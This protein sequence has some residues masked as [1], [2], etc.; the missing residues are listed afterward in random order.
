MFA[1]KIAENK[2]GTAPDTGTQPAD[3]LAIQRKL[4]VGPA[5]DPLEQEADTMADRVMRMQEPGFVQRK[6]HD[7]EKEEHLQ[8][9]PTGDGQ[10]AVSDQTADTIR[11]SA[12]KGSVLDGSAA[13]FMSSRMGN[14]FGDIKIHTD[15][16]AVQLSREL[17]ARAFT[18]G[19]DIYFNEGEYQPGSESGRHLLAH[20]LT[21]TVQQGGTQPVVQKKDAVPDKLEAKKKGI[22]EALEHSD[23][24]LFLSRLR[25]LDPAEGGSLLADTDF[26]QAIRRKFSGSALWSAFTILFFHGKMSLTQRTL[27]VALSGKKADDVLDA[28]AVITARE[29]IGDPMYWDVLKDVVLVIFE[30]DPKLPD[31]LQLLTL[32]QSEY[33]GPRNLTLKSNEVHYEENAAHHYAID[34]FGSNNRA[35]AYSTTKEFRVV[36]TIRLVDGHPSEH[37]EIKD[38]PYTF[39]GRDESGIP[40]AWIAGIKSIWNNRFVLANGIDTLKF[41]VA[42]RF[43]YEKGEED[44]TVSI[45]NNHSLQCPN[46]L[47][48]G[49]ANAGCWFTDESPVV[50]AHE[51]G[52]LMGAKDEYQLPGSLAEVPADKLATLSEEDKKLTTMTGIKNDEL[53]PGA[54]P[55]GPLP[56]KPPKG[57]SVKGLMGD[58]AE[59]TEVKGRHIRFLVNA[60]NASQPVGTPPYTIRKI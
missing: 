33:S 23:A 4:S 6:C 8:R 44:V 3:R 25:A 22:L 35:V 28:V 18:V 52:H 30:G 29:N 13:S 21:H 9:Q 48:P 17:S 31:L 45:M 39:R 46:V 43:T 1:N 55:V 56:A 11:S 53:P 15:G 54:S 12:G 59:S 57:E 7:C 38:Q 40:D 32:R 49:R 50:I 24:M 14:D 27:S 5:N 19:R 2:G 20:E 51:F 47:Q 42:P 60:F 41:T 37:P 16:E 58:H 10:P 26:W 34:S 36:I